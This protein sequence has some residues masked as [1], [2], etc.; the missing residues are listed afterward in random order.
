MRRN[1]P[2]RKTKPARVIQK[3][4]RKPI[5]P[6]HCPIVGVPFEEALKITPLLDDLHAASMSLAV[7]KFAG[8][9]PI[10][11]QTIVA[12]ILK[13]KDLV[14]YSKKGKHLLEAGKAVKMASKGEELAKLV[15]K[16]GTIIE[17]ARI[18]KTAKATAKFANVTGM[19]FSAA[20]ML[21][22]IETARQLEVI[23][24]DVK[25]LRDARFIS[26]MSELERIYR[27]AKELLCGELDDGAKRRLHEIAHDLF[28]LRAEWRR[29]LLRDIESIE[30]V[31]AGP[32]ESGYFWTEKVQHGY[33]DEKLKKLTKAGH[34]VHLIHFTVILQMALSFSAGKGREFLTATLPDEVKD[35]TA[36]RA[37]VAERAEFIRESSRK[38]GLTAQP[39]LDYFDY[40]AAQYEAFVLGAA[41]LEAQS[42][43]TKLMQLSPKAK[44]AKRKRS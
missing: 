17:N 9:V 36:V 20:Q 12:R 29:E 7:G 32:I 26:Q 23:G 34:D 18:V 22:A 37:K 38:A 10:A 27:S 16:N 3:S 25:F 19:V 14:D 35:W 1:R 4:G 41:N 30:N 42:P 39:T 24:K 13:G 11:T 15:G 21:A 6:L 40:L 44:T 43:T 28:R 33:D 31:S 5:L 8:A 2:A